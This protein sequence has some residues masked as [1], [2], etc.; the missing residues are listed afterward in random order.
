[1]RLSQ[2]TPNQMFTRH[3][4]PCSHPVAQGLG[5]CLHFLV[6]S[7]RTLGDPHARQGKCSLAGA[8][9]DRSA[10]LANHVLATDALPGVGQA[11]AKVV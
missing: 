8:E 3:R 5:K 7:N 6:R 9:H 11:S 4:G 10:C 2:G 1:M